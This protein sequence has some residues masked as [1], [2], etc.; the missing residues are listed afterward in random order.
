MNFQHNGRT[1]TLVQQGSTDRDLTITEILALLPDALDLIMKIKQEVAEIKKGKKASIAIAL[2]VQEVIVL[3]SKV[4][5][6]VD[7]A[8]LNL[9]QYQKAEAYANGIIALI[10]ENED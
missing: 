2:I 7:I 1:Y 9:N 5:D 8:E 6:K 3:V 10:L 4:I